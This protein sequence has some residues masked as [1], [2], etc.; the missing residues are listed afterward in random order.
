MSKTRRLDNLAAIV[1]EIDVL[2]ALSGSLNVAY[3]HD[4]FEDATYVHI[5]LEC[6]HGV[7]LQ[8]EVD[9]ETEVRHPNGYWKK[10]SS[11]S[12]LLSLVLATPPPLL[13]VTLPDTTVELGGLTYGGVSMTVGVSILPSTQ[14]LLSTLRWVDIPENLRTSRPHQPHTT[15]ST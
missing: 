10:L 3:L 15:C 5:V 2:R 13:S 12:A 4:V 6:C 1:R 9:S 7:D 11:R 8:G 14:Q